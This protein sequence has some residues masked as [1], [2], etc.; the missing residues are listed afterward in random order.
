MGQVKVSAVTHQVM[1]TRLSITVDFRVIVSV[2]AMLSHLFSPRP[3][4]IRTVPNRDK[5]HCNIIHMFYIFTWIG[6]DSHARWKQPE[7]IWNSF[8]SFCWAYCGIASSGV[9][10]LN[11]SR[12]SWET[13]DRYITRFA[14]L[15]V[16]R[17][18]QSTHE[19]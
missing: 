14:K 4:T 11:P 17:P 18:I 15:I 7:V 5:S 1:I 13:R 9:I 6:L 10:G 8:L 3:S 2:F 12:G 16:D 19:T